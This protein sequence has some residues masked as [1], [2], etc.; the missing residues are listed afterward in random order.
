MSTFF[1]SP[2]FLWALWVRFFLFHFCR[3]F[4]FHVELCVCNRTKPNILFCYGNYYNNNN[5][6]ASLLNSYN[7]FD[8]KFSLWPQS[9]NTHTHTHTLFTLNEIKRKWNEKYQ[10]CLPYPVIQMQNWCNWC[11]CD[12]QRKNFKL[13]IDIL[14]FYFFDL[15]GNYRMHCIPNVSSVDSERASTFTDFD[16]AKAIA[17]H[18]IFTK[19]YKPSK[20]NRIFVN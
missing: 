6:C 9:T 20:P 14:R 19:L 15:L 16:M 3:A 4:L 17:F 18:F 8:W 2:L 1:F 5:F 10:I 12:Q 7:I 13:Q 11:T